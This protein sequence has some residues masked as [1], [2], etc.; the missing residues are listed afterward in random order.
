MVCRCP[1]QSTAVISDF[2]GGCGLPPLGVP[3]QPP[4]V[5]PVTSQEGTVIKHYLLLLSFPWELTYPAA[6]TSRCSGTL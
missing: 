2:R 1:G 6:A 4:L 5:A 3:E